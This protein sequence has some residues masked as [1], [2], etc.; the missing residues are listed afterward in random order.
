MKLLYAHDH[1]FR[2]DGSDYYSGG[3]FSNNIL[4][5]YFSVF[6]PFQLVARCVPMDQ[7]ADRLSKVDQSMVEILPIQHNK[8]RLHT[9]VQQSDCV[10]CR[11]PSFIGNKCVSLAKKYN[12]PYLIE[13][14]DQ[15]GLYKYL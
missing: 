7:S 8:D 6:G 12:K 5:R 11:L 3:S 2:Y 14:V 15:L 10:I 1:K 9:L 4:K 13:L